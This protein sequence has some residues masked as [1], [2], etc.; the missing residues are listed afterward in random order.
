MES[1]EKPGVSSTIGDARTKKDNASNDERVT[2]NYSGGHSGDK[3]TQQTIARLTGLAVTTVSR[4]LANDPKIAA[5]TRERVLTTAR[6]IGYVPDRAAQ[7]LRTGR[8][9]VVSLVLDPHS[10]ILG[11][12]NSM[13]TG[14]AD[15]VRGTRYHLTVMQ[16]Q[17][18][19]DPLEP[20]RFIVRNRQADGILFAR[21]T[22][23]DPRAAFLLEQ[24]FPFVTHGRTDLQSH[25]W[26]DYDNY[27]FA[28]DAVGRL[29]ARGCRRIGIVPPSSR[30]M[31]HDHMMAGY[32]DGLGF[33]GLTSH[34]PEDFDLNMEA[35][36]LHPGLRRWLGSSDRP[37]G[38][39]C[40]GEV[41]AII[42]N[43]AILDAGLSPDRDIALIAKRTSD[44]F[45]HL[46]PNVESLREDIEEAGRIMMRLLLRQ[47]D[48]EAP[49]SL[50]VLASP[51]AYRPSAALSTPT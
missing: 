33:F 38:I 6:E 30:F 25:A 13:I 28:R 15:I 2:M 22:R 21:T 47:L 14:I 18:G 35:D 42:A 31:Y 51:E 4:A 5:K 49:E 7:R 17:L 11:F 1:G 26:Y 23:Q 34:I 29:A 50:Q 12:G 27:A 8:T 48:G 45:K 43:A 32:R 20:I 3:P 41:S 37:D 10:E 36:R 16:Y 39:I 9:N 46:R 40:P 44:I 19:E 24:K